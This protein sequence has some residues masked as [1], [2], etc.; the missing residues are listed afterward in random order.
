MESLTE[1][2]ARAAC[3]AALVQ[4][5]ANRPG[6]ICLTIE[7]DD[8][9]VSRDR[10][11]LYRLARAAG[12]SQTLEYRH[13]RSYEEPLLALPDMVAWCWGRSADWRRRVTPIVGAVR[14][15]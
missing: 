4:D 7:R 2:D 3:L 5:L 14:T 11:E 12:I 13:R 6:N 15:V 1:G 9:I 10:S 8:S